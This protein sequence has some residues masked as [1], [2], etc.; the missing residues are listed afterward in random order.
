[1][2]KFQS[3]DVMYTSFQ[4]HFKH[5]NEFSDI[6]FSVQRHSAMLS[7]R[8]YKKIMDVCNVKIYCDSYN[9][10]SCECFVQDEKKKKL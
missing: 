5:T 8:F 10:Y 7:C 1:M 4:V 9:N 3:K 6:F 2:N